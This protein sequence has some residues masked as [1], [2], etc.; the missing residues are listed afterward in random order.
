MGQEGDPSNVRYDTIC[1]A[2]SE[3]GTGMPLT[4]WIAEMLGGQKVVAKIVAIAKIVQG[5][6]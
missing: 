3:L 2:H 6:R 4:R 1:C 5:G